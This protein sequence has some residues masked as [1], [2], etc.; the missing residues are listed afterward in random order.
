MI[1]SKKDL[2]PIKVVLD[3]YEHYYKNYDGPLYTRLLKEYIPVAKRFYTRLTLAEIAYIMENL[4]PELKL[5]L[6]K[7]LQSY[8]SKRKH[9][10]VRHL[11]QLRKFYHELTKGLT[12]NMLCK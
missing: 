8:Q 7:K 5:L 2:V 10:W 9:H 1:A 4:T 12:N 3:I 11:D 6:S